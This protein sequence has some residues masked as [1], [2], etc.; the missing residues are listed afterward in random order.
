MLSQSDGRNGG[1]R[2][3]MKRHGPQQIIAMLRKAEVALAQRQSAAWVSHILGI[4]EQTLHRYRWV[5]GRLKT[6]K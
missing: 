5:Y 6:Y 3:C 2:M 4:A 1:R